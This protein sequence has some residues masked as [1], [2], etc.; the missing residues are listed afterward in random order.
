[1][2]IVTNTFQFFFNKLSNLPQRWVR[3]VQINGQSIESEDVRLVKKMLG[4][5]LEYTNHAV[6]QQ[7]EEKF[8]RLNQS[9]SAFSFLKGRVALSACIAA[10]DLKPGDKVILP[11]YTCV[12]VANAF[13][14]AGIEVHFCDIELDTFGLDFKAVQMALSKESN[15]KAIVVQHSYGLVCRDFEKLLQLSKD[16]QLPIIEDCTHA[17]G[18]T[19]RG[20]PVGNW[21]NLA[22]FS[23]EHSK[24]FSTFCGGMAITN[25]E[26]LANKLSVFQTK[27]PFPNHHL[28]T[29]MLQ[30]VLFNYYRKRFNGR[31]FLYRLF[32]KKLKRARISTTTEEEIKGKK[33]TTY[34]QKMPP[35]LARLG[36]LQLHK[37]ESIWQKRQLRTK[38][39]TAWVATQEFHPPHITPESDPILLRYPILVTE[40]MKRDHSWA[41][42]LKVE[43]GVWFISPLHPS[44]IDIGRF[45]N[46]EKAVKCCI[47]LP[48]LW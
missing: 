23:S 33:P 46:A 11:A 7:Y 25:D 43:I 21:G 48:T 10:L 15:L 26:H 34:L 22:F 44:N 29:T 45:P 3:R 27:M 35:E 9:S 30:N 42:D 40:E 31:P 24:P 36:L 16:N 32:T 12:V 14:F 2:S 4:N 1:V 19:F 47:N 5:D 37:I 20:R 38:Y 13:W 39:W 41:N 28:T 6:I 8:A 17:F 18:S